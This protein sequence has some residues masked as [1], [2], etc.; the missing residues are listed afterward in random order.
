MKKLVY[1]A[2]GL[3]IGWWCTGM[4]YTSESSKQKLATEYA[5]KLEKELEVQTNVN[6]MVVNSMAESAKDRAMTA[7]KR[8][9]LIMKVLAN[10]DKMSKQQIIKTL[11]KALATE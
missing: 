5:K 11:S 3:V 4:Y 9:S 1:I 6:K 8:D 2:V 10:Y 7:Y